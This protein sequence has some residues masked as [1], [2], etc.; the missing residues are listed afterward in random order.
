M[1][2]TV[3]SWTAPNLLTIAVMMLLISAILGAVAKI[4]VSKRKV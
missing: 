3:I 1:N 2:E 4:V